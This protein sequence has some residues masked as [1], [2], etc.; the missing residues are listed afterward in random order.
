MRGG[1]Y[2]D[3]SETDGGE[4]MSIELTS[5]IRS[6]EFIYPMDSENMKHYPEQLALSVLRYFFDEY[7][8][9]LVKDAPDLQ[10]SDFSTGIEVT[11][12]TV[13]KNKAIDG[14]YLQYRKTKDEKYLE[15]IREKG[16]TATDICYGV[17]PVTKNDEL[18][19]MKA[20]FE[21]KLKKISDYKS[22]GFGSIGLAMVM[23]E[24][25]IPH[26]AFEWGKMIHILN[27]NSKEKYDMIFLLIRVL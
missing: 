16:G 15:K 17:L 27:S 19:A 22:K 21:K 7:D 6:K 25:P 18:E 8:D 20:V 24:I 4:M 1:T 2:E 23:T 5:E 10:S 9:F 11:E 26:T 14:D 13:S 12:I 3:V